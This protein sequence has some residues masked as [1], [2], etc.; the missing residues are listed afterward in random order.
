MIRT[1]KRTQVLLA[2]YTGEPLSDQVE[3]G[4][5]AIFR[6]V[7]CIQLG[8]VLLQLAVLVVSPSRPLNLIGWPIFFG[9]TWTTVLALYLFAGTLQSRLGRWYL[10]LALLIA[11]VCTFGDFY[12][13]LRALSLV[14]TEHPQ[15][16]EQFG[17]FH[18][19]VL[20]SAGGW[21]LLVG[22]LTPLVIIA[23]Q[24]RL[25]TVVLY[26][27]LIAAAELVSY[28]VFV[29]I[30]APAERQL[31]EPIFVGVT[32]THAIVFLLMGTIVNRILRAQRQHRQAL[33]SANEQLAQHAAT[34]EQLTV[35][36]E[37][38][39]L[40]REM[41]DT[42]A[43]TL[44]A[45]AVQLE[46]VDSAWES[47]P[48]KARELLVKSLGQTRSGLTETRRTL[49][50]LR[51]SPLEDLGLALAV[52]TL[53]ESTAKRAGLHLELAIDELEP[54]SP[55]VEQQLY[56]IAQEALVNVFKHSAASTL[57]VQLRQEQ[58]LLTLAIED[59]GRGFV[60]DQ[61][62]AD[63]GGNGHYGLR[64]MCERAELI[65]AELAIMA[66]GTQGTRIQLSLREGKS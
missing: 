54:L 66:A 24:Y 12:W 27:L 23:S 35:S 65:G 20:L 18:R 41:H 30:P 22:L 9:I 31:F 21:N 8:L 40:A 4:L 57:R 13:G 48:A 64:G 15:W 49:Q 36:R 58:G 45:V 26:V 3:P 55:E 16:S 33:A 17:T 52:R 38:N 7:V 59:D 1:M 10:P 43:H 29:G 37:R 53:A 14:A 61:P 62:Q 2:D 5:L 51:A 42:L 46:A 6:T 32:L 39:R 25:R 56:R 28:F 44:S 47:N 19:A 34:L 60:A 50:A 11:T 63:G